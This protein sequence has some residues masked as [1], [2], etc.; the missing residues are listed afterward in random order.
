[1]LLG[2]RRRTA[3]FEV[4]ALYSQLDP[5]FP[6]VS[7]KDKLIVAAAI[8]LRIAYLW[9]IEDAIDWITDDRDD[10]YSL[11]WFKGTL[12]QT[13]YLELLKLLQDILNQVLAPAGSMVDRDSEA[14]AE[15]YRQYKGDLYR[16]GLNGL[17]AAYLA[18]GLAF[19]ALFDADITPLQ[20]QIARQLES[21]TFNRSEPLDEEFEADWIFGEY[22]LGLEAI[23]RRNKAIAIAAICIRLAKNSEMID[24]LEWVGPEINNL[25]LFTDLSLTS[26]EVLIPFCQRMLDQLS[27]QPVL[28]S[29]TDDESEVFRSYYEQYR[30]NYMREASDVLE[31]RYSAEQ[32]A[33][34][35]FY[36]DE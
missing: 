14:F 24:A 9:R 11:T 13:D 7:R 18:E 4:R 25:T 8:A 15:A 30:R 35:A 31:A 16:Q 6:S 20:L 12:E 21:S 34:T 33:F 2:Q 1:M 36:G 29:P 5:G 32:S 3:D 22:G 28:G 23:S 10:Q 26:W 17:H 19:R 27:G